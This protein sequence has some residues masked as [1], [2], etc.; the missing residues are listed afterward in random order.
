MISAS[1]FRRGSKFLYKNEP[2]IVLDH[3]SVKPG[4][5][6]AFMRTK[7]KNMITGLVH[8]E[9]FRVEEKFPT[10]DLE[11]H[12][13]NYLYQDGD[14]YNF[15]DQES[16][17]QVLLNKDQLSE[18]LDY[19]KEQTVYNVLYFEGSPIAVTPPLHMDLK[20]TETVPGIRGDTAQGGA[21]KPATLETGL[22]L[23]VPLFV[24]EGDLVRIDTRDGKYIERV[25]K[26]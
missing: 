9:T 7:M 15:M 20:V 19:L 1:E 26:K 4:K 18:V 24:E 2:Y 8:E 16:Y 14:Q 22:V 25:N 10:P 5:G 6:G 11:Y 3:Q 21:T 13:M 23:Q 17:D 12:E